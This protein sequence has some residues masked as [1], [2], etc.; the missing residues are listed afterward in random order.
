M[1]ELE[2]MDSHR[3]FLIPR[4][5]ELSRVMRWRRWMKKSIISAAKIGTILSPLLLSLPTKP[6]WF[7]SANPSTFIALYVSTK[8]VNSRDFGNTVVAV[9]F[10]MENVRNC[11][12]QLLSYFHL[13]STAW[14]TPKLQNS[15][16]FRCH[17]DYPIIPKCA[18][19]TPKAQM[20]L[21]NLRWKFGESFCW[22]DSSIIQ[23]QT[24][25]CSN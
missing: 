6:W 7:H 17:C 22:W 20:N 12:I 13:L 16:D 15:G 11:Q 14:V 4:E 3:D 19:Y 23:I 1:K 5:T 21:S 18:I 8:S 24:P 9:V 25:K 2:W 10:V